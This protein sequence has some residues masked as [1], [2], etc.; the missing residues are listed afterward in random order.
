MLRETLLQHL[1]LQAEAAAAQ[2][3]TT[4]AADFIAKAEGEG[5]MPA[6]VTNNLKRIA[7][8][9]G[10]NVTEKTKA[11]DILQQ[12]KAKSGPGV[13][14]EADAIARDAELGLVGHFD[15]AGNYVPANRPDRLMP[16]PQDG[17]APGQGRSVF[18]QIDEIANMKK[19]VVDDIERNFGK[20]ILADPVAESSLRKLEKEMSQKIAET[21]L[22]S[23][24][25]AKESVDFT[26]LNYGDKTY[27]DQALA[28]LYPYH[29]WYKG[30]YKNWMKRIAT[31][32]QVLAHYARY[33]ENLGLVHNDMQEWWKY[34]LNSND[35]PG[36]DTDN[37]LYF[38]LEA[39]LWPLNGITGT[40]FNDSS[41][42]VD[43]WTKTLDFA[44]KFGPSVWSPI[45]IM[46]GIALHA[47][48][49]EEA[50]AKWMGRL[51]PQSA[52]I[53]AVAS[54]FGVDN[55]EVDPLVKMFSGNLDPYEENRV[56][57]AMAQMAQEA[58]DGNSKY[59]VEQIQ[60]A[61]YAQEG[62]IWDEAVKRAVHGRSGAQLSSFLFG[63][64]FKG[65]TKEDMEIDNFYQD[66]GKVWNMKGALSTEEF[67]EGMAALQKKYPFMDTMLL[68]RR[69][70]IERDAGLAYLVMQR[71]PPGQMTDIANAVD[72]DPKLLDKFFTDKGQ[73]DKWS[74]SDRTKF[75]AGILTMSA[76][77]EIPTDMT[78]EEW[79]TAKNAYADMQT[80]AKRRFGSNILDTL[81]GYYQ[82]KTVGYDAA[83]AFLE[84]HPEVSDYMNWK[85]E[86]VMGSPLL[87]AY[88]GGASMIEGYYRSQMYS[89]I[90]EKLGPDV[91][92]II[93]EYNDLKTY[94]TEQEY[95]N[96]YKQ[97]KRAISAYYDLKDEWY[98]IIDQNVAKL[99][100]NI[101]EGQGA[102]IR[103]DY[104][105]TSPTQ[106]ELV[107]AV[108]PQQQMT[109]QDFQD[110]IPERVL[111]LVQD[112]IFN[113]QPLPPSVEKQLG[114][115][116]GDFGYGNASD[117]IQSIGTSMY[118]AVGP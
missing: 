43:W 46:T 42:R 98:I 90:E 70:S 53:K 41:R 56:K 77:L 15:E 26:L 8:E 117:L 44:G 64:G 71:I 21:R 91:F 62:E 60:E 34:N 82:A 115:L 33:K 81:D 95:K 1:P 35:L 45:N 116:A 118:Q 96:F 20:K 61:A 11:S 10:I 38:N 29:F 67:K 88:Y 74:V 31:N 52:S 92:T 73:I 36:V 48:G 24:R 109:Y 93:D 94:G 18:D 63:V 57:R 5:A 13:L 103:E 76:V 105:V 110:R 69:D 2:G 30:T 106:T 19:W 16:P 97:N 108:T 47:R 87:S 111:N 107:G 32:P 75:M 23:S 114:R 12:L 39:T 99:S 101:P 86:R 9:N 28:Y 17:A 6:F 14:S 113:G 83:D 37:P 72:V 25:V 7:R 104:D 3:I 59:S 40:D 22:I 65:R 68:A 55:L 51:F 27:G 50:G 4:E 89:D 79:T 100:A 80:D 78:R 85:A 112:Y 58:E 84:L 49:E 54:K 102:T 66:Y